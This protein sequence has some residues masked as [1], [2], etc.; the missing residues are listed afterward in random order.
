MPGLHGIIVYKILP[1]LAE[2]LKREGL[3]SDYDRK[4]EK[5]KISKDF[6][7]IWMNPDLILHMSNGKKILVEVANP[8]DP[9]RFI[10]ELVYPKMLLWRKKITA[11]MVFVLKPQEQETPK[12]RD[13]H[14]R[15]LAQIHM[16]YESLN[17]PKGSK[18]VT[19]PGEDAA[20]GWL[21]AFCSKRV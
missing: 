12:K 7:E 9:K 10:G 3:I 4:Q 17:M 8:E 16:L 20:Y 6:P 11:A 14:T 13:L 2:K 21:K 18:I 1:W 19:W 5:I 15:S